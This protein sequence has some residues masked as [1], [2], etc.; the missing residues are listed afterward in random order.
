M[1]G[2]A[3]IFAVEPFNVVDDK[4]SIQS[5]YQILYIG[6]IITIIYNKNNYLIN[7]FN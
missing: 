6:K 1:I 2:Y 7:I 3:Q 5:F 4:R